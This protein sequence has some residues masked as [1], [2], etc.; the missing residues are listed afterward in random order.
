MI[1]VSAGDPRVEKY[2]TLRG[3]VGADGEEFI[4]DGEKV[5]TRLLEDDLNIEIKGL[6]CL[7]KYLHRHQAAIERKGVAPENIFYSS[8]RAMADS[9]G[10]KI[11]QGMMALARKPAYLDPADLAGPVVVLNGVVSAEN[12]GSIVRNALAF[13]VR[14]ILVDQKTCD[15]YIRRAVRVSMGSVFDARLARS[16]NLSASLEELKSREIV[17]VAA[18]SNRVRGSVAVGEYN[19]PKKYAL[20]IGNEGEGVA[21]EILDK[22]GDRVY[23]PM[24][25]NISSLNA[26]AAT[27]ALLT[28]ASLGN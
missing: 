23:I 26:A 3:L 2:K 13:N 9:L 28:A 27:A 12:V 14:D 6:Y 24:Y 11:H 17:P 1:E 19:F 7:E 20:I 4:C 16:E 18:S 10:Y 5:V 22:I 15:P 8:R 25:N 21:P